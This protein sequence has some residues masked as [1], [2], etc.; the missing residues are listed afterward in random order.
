MQKRIH[1]TVNAMTTIDD[2]KRAIESKFV[3]DQELKFRAEGHRNRL[4]ATWAAPIVGKT[5]IDG[6]TEEVVDVRFEDILYFD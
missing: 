3:H 2:C 5:D 6:C 4:I 1:Q